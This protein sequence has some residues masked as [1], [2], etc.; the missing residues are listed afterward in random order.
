MNLWKMFITENNYENDQTNKCKFEVKKLKLKSHDEIQ[1]SILL[2]HLHNINAWALPFD[3]L[4]Q[5]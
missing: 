5:N 3:L 4:N 1:R 2:K